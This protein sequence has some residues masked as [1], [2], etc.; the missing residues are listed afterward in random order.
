M[1]YIKNRPI[2][3]G[4]E[5]KEIQQPIA[6]DGWSNDTFSKLYGKDKNPAT[7]T[8]RDRSF[9]RDGFVSLEEV[10]ESKCI[11]GNDKFV[12]QEVCAD[13]YLEVKRNGT[14]TRKRGRATP[15]I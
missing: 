6:K 3:T 5:L 13:C 1:V 4:Q 15:K 7:G 9:R 2:I 14:K 8:E 12:W 11:C 10:E